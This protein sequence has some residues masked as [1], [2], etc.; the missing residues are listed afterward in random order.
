MK[1]IT[2]DFN[3]LNSQIDRK[4]CI[5]LNHH[6]LILIRKNSFALSFKSNYIK[7]SDMAVFCVTRAAHTGASIRRSFSPICTSYTLT[8]SGEEC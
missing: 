3:Q 4:Q 8:L 1:F 7:E 6:A 2:I 5:G